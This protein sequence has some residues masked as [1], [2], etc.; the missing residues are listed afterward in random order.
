[1]TRFVIFFSLTGQTIARFIDQPSDRAAAVRGLLEPVGGFGMVTGCECCVPSKR[2]QPAGIV[3]V[4]P[5]RLPLVRSERC[6]E[7]RLSEIDLMAA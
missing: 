4:E 3:E 2:V 5:V 1:M 7:R 6:G